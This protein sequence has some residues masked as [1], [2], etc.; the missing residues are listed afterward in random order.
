MSILAAAQACVCQQTLPHPLPCT[1]S[2]PLGL[3]ATSQV[4]YLIR[5]VF[6]S[7]QKAG[8]PVTAKGMIRCG[9]DTQ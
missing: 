5:E 1:D 9:Q 7:C 6:I 3:N 2:M 4:P 8:F